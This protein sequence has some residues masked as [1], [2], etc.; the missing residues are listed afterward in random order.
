MT[1][2]SELAAFLRTRR[3]RL[4]PADVGLPDG[5]NRR[6]PGL[7]RQEVAQLAGISVDY[8]VRLEQARGAKP[9]RQ[10]LA[11]LAR[12]LMLTV[13]EREYL[14]RM[15]GEN[16]PAVAGPNRTVPQSVRIILDTL[17]APAYVVDATYEVLAWN[18]GAVP[19]IGDIDA[20]PEQE[21]NMVRWMFHQAHDHPQWS[22]ESTRCFARSTV[23]DLRAAYARYPGNPAL[24]SLVTE[25]LGTSTRFADMWHAH[26]VEVRRA[27]HKRVDH[28]ALGLLE[29]ECQVMHISDTDQ[30]MIVYCA[31]PGSRTADVFRT[32][33]DGQATAAYGAGVYRKLAAEQRAG[34]SERPAPLREPRSP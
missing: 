5:I 32:L 18:R 20:D 21:R 24:S 14:Y 15:G 1:D 13:D 3:N 31:P 25:L 33:A 8:Y 4:S 16:P 11:A 22:N 26:E 28:P 34:A 27:H 17:G 29:F 30:R 9:S 12:A 10:V 7:R 2:R 6:A 23:A 19:F